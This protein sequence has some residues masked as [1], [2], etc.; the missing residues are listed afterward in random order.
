MIKILLT[1]KNFFKRLFK[2][3]Q[4]TEI[5]TEAKPEIT[6]PVNLR[7]EPDKIKKPKRRYYQLDM[8]NYIERNGTIY[9]N[10]PKVRMKKKERIKKRWAGRED[11]RF[12]NGKRY[13]SE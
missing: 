1:I 4:K 11:E 6:V 2:R 9:R 5:K 3:K 8:T 13:K 10:P 12:V 7:K